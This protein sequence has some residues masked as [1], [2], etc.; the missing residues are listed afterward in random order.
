MGNGYVVVISAY[1]ILQRI[2]FSVSGKALR[3]AHICNYHGDISTLY[4]KIG[5]ILKVVNS[6][7]TQLGF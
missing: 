3:A 2:F 7:L 6:P 4:I 1:K 5:R